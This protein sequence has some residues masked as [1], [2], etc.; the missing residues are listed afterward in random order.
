V[1]RAADSFDKLL[2]KRQTDVA[3]SLEQIYL[4]HGVR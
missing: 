1:Y 4:G 2:R 3:R